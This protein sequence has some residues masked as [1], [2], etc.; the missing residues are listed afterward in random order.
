[1]PQ[2][3]ARQ[4]VRAERTRNGRVVINLDRRRKVK[5][6]GISEDEARQ[7]LLELV[8]IASPINC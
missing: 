2:I 1:M 5:Q 8:R 3:P 4:T 6:I 7:L